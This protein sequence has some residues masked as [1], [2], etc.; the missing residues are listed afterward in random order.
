MTVDVTQPTSQDGLTLQELSLYHSIMAYRASLGLAA[1]PLSRGLTTTAGRHVADTRENIWAASLALPAGTSLHSWSD[2][3]YYADNRDPSVM[4]TA[5]QRVNSGYTSA[6]YEISAAGFATTDLALE[7][8]KASASHNAIIA[9]TGVWAGID[10]KAIGIGVDTSEGAGIYKG[11]VF[12]V[13]FGETTDAAI[14]DISGTTAADYVL[15]TLFADRI[16]AGAGAD[17]VYG[18]DGADEL[19]GDGGSDKLYGDAGAD[20]LFGG[21]GDDRLQGGAGDD[22]LNGGAGADRLWGNDGADRLN[23]AAGADILIGGLGGDRLTGGAGADTFVF[24]AAAESP[25]GAGNRTVITDLQPGV[26]HI[27]LSRIDAVPATAGDDAFAFI[28]A[29]A[30][31]GHAGE[32]R[33]SASVLAIDLDGDRVPD[34]QIQ[35]GAPGALAADDFIL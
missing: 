3:P 17:E 30:F 8:W 6:G 18:S 26:D 13:W 14:P 12:H 19:R 7:G 16:L 1:I 29:A 35:I 22:V 11:R 33:Q 32:I 21:G 15:G 24:N 10:L 23:G 31:T 4:W 5:P 34:M 28:G 20:T 2:A 9:Q 25:S 27:D